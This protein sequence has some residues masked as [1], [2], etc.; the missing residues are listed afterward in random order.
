MVYL[1]RRARYFLLAF[2]KFRRRPYGPNYEKTGAGGAFP[3]TRF[4]GD[5][6]AGS[7]DASERS[8]FFVRIVWHPRTGR[9][10]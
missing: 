1:R 8:R 9:L 4:V 3:V 10:S 5:I 7:A 2:D 6:A